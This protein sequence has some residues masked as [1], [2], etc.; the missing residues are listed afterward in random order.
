MLL[1]VSPSNPTASRWRNS[2]C[3][4]GSVHFHDGQSGS[5]ARAAPN[6]TSTT[7]YIQALWGRKMLR[8]RNRALQTACSP[9]ARL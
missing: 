3:T 2:A 6:S 7:K 8:V 9:A 4:A 1:F 5:P